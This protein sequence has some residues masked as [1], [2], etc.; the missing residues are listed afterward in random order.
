MLTT[1][2]L[3]QMGNHPIVDDLAKLSLNGL[4]QLEQICNQSD[5]MDRPCEWSSQAIA[6]R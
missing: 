6:Y 5:P 4:T 2:N 3:K 1:Q